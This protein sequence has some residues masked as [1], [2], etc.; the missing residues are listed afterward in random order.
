[1]VLWES[2]WRGAAEAASLRNLARQ[3]D[4]PARGAGIPQLM[5]TGPL[6]APTLQA[7]L[8]PVILAQAKDLAY[9]ALLKV[10]DTG[11]PKQSFTTDPPEGRG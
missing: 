7:R 2:H 6:T 8:H 9:Q 3:D 5:G 1:M 11:K 4:D 10:P